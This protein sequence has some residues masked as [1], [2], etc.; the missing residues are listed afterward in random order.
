VPGEL[1][2]D[3]LGDLVVALPVDRAH[4]ADV[5]GEM[6]FVYEMS[7]RGLCRERGMPVRDVLGGA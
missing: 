2:G 7:Q 3:G 5:A 4:L 1:P 6:P